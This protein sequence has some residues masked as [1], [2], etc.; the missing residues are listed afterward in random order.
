MIKKTFAIVIAAACMASGAASAQSYEYRNDRDGRADYQQRSSHYERRNYGDRQDGYRGNDDRRDGYRDN[1]YR[2]DGY[3]G[4]D[5]R[6]DRQSM[7]D[8][9]YRHS[10]QRPY[11]QMRRGERVAQYYSG[12]QYVVRD[13]NRHRGLYAPYRGHQ[14]VQVGNDYALVAI[15]TGIIAQVLLNN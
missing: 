11:Y 15:A 2:G 7:Y 1:G 5:Y 12:N 6:R 9:R 3:R 8:Q 14:W 13:W 10:T 4:N